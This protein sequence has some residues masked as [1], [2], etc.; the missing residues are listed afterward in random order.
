MKKKIKDLTNVQ[1]WAYCAF[2]SISCLDCPFHKDGK[3]GVIHCY[4]Q[5]PSAFDKEFLEKEIELV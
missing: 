5:T 1:I 2:K 4:S 3:N